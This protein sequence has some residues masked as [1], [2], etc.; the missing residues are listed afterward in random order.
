[1]PLASK[2]FPAHYLAGVRSHA[3]TEESRRA[4]RGGGGFGVFHEPQQQLCHRCGLDLGGGCESYANSPT[5]L[6]FMN[7]HTEHPKRFTVTAF[8]GQCLAVDGGLGSV[9]PQ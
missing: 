3:C 7:F 8:A 4:R 2:V 1:M 5:P 9:K 6:L